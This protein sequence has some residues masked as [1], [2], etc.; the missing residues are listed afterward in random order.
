MPAREREGVLHGVRRKPLFI[1]HFL[2]EDTM[3]TIDTIL[4]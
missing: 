1:R 3:D 4:G 2:Q